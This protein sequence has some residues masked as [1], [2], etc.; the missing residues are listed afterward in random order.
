[1]PEYAAKLTAVSEAAE[2]VTASETDLEQARERLRAALKA[3][4]RAGAPYSL[5]GD[6]AGLSRQRVAQLVAQE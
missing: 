4:H 2:A 1:M 3:A 5:L 6:L